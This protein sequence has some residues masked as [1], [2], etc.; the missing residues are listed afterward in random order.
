MN[1]LKYVMKNMVIYQDPVYKI[2]MKLALVWIHLVVQLI[3]K[4]ALNEN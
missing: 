4:K 1:L 2:W 3:I